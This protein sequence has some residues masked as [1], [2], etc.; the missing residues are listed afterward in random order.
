LPLIFVIAVTA[1]KQ[2]YE[3]LLRYRADNI[4]N[5]SLVT[6]IRKSVEQEIKCEDIMPGDLVKL[7]RDCDI[8]CD[9][10]LLKSSAENKCSITTA[11]L[12]EFFTLYESLS[13]Y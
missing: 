2:G 10:V 1:A 5:Q 3:D 7:T 13:N 11:N 4:V 9:M 12:G 6:V 8:P